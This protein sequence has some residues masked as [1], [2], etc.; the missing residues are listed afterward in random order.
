[1]DWISIV[2]YCCNVA[3]LSFWIF[4][5]FTYLLQLNRYELVTT[6][7]CN[8]AKIIISLLLLVL[9]D[10]IEYLFI[11]VLCFDMWVIRSLI[12]CWRVICIYLL[13]KH[14][15]YKGKLKFTKR[16]I[17]Q[18][19][20]FS[21]GVIGCCFLIYYPGLL[22]FTLLIIYLIIFLLCKCV[23]YFICQMYIYT[24]KSKLK[25]YANI[26]II[27]ITGSFGKTSTKNFLHQILQSKY[28]VLS[29]PKSYNTQMGV[30]K[31][32]LDSDLKNIEYLI[33]EMGAVRKGDIFKLCKMVDPDI[34]VITNIGNQ[35]LETFRC[36]DNIIST[37]NELFDYI[38]KK[39]GMLFYNL[40]N[41][42][43]CNLFINE[44]YMYK[45][46]IIVSNVC[47]YDNNITYDD[48]NRRN[49]VLNTCILNICKYGVNFKI[50]DIH[51]NNYVYL[52][53]K[54]LGKGF[55]EDIALAISISLYLGVDIDIIKAVVAMLDYIP[56][57]MELKVGF[58]GASIIYDA[59][60]SNEFSYK[61]ML[62][63]VTKFEAKHKIL[64]TPGVVE[65]GRNQYSVNVELA[66]LSKDVFD[67]IWIINKVNKYAFLVG[68]KDCKFCKIKTFDR[69]DDN[70]FSL[71]NSFDSDN[72]I[73]FENDL[74]DSY[75]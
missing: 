10:L 2:F 14:F 39:N 48:I 69:L 16:V 50:F 53:T 55:I 5:I 68:L 19:V 27:G 23:E 65:L 74:P 22:S 36:V 61:E 15:L 56:N 44:S 54:L 58:G 57:R 28:I 1:M 7:R 29:S 21:L 35:H 40:N 73:V 8:Y 47:E 17:R 64:I 70:V 46:G 20:L 13:M 9:I 63:T 31:F 24:A 67:E 18:C 41:Q 72:L 71:V 43:L 3:V 45:Y 34:G 42:Y 11:F 59:Y 37:K 12:L 4:Y 75:Y 62:N 32:I 52:S 33:I 60:N 25:K 30:C 66:K 26:K 38:K 6:I 49:N 51:K